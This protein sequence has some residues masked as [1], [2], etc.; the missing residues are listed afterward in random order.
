MT[1]FKSRNTVKRITLTPNVFSKQNRQYVDILKSVTSWN[2]RK[3][4]NIVLEGDYGTGKSSII[5]QLLSCRLW[6]ILH[7]PKC[8]SFLSFTLHS[9][10]SIAADTTDTTKTIQSEIIRQLCYGESP[11]TLK[12]TTYRCSG[13]TYWLSSA[14]AAV[15]ALI[16]FAIQNGN[17]SPMYFLLK[18]LLGTGSAQ[19]LSDNL[20][21]IVMSLRDEI[22][23]AISW[24]ITTCAINTII[25]ALAS[26]N[27]TRLSASNISVEFGDNQMDFQKMSDFLALY[28]RRTRHRVIV[29]E[30]LDRFHD[31]RIFEELRRLNTL[32]N[33]S[34][35]SWVHPKIKFIYTAS[36]D[37]RDESSQACYLNRDNYLGQGDEPSQTYSLNQRAKLFDIII[38]VVPF[39]STFNLEDNFVKSG[40]AMLENTFKQYSAQKVLH[41]SPN[42]ES[43]QAQSQKVLDECRKTLQ[44]FANILSRNGA[45]MR[46]CRLVLAYFESFVQ[47]YH[48][49]YRGDPSSYT[50]CLALS[51]IRAYYP[52][53][54][55]KLAFGQSVLNSIET[56]C[57]DSRSFSKIHDK[58]TLAS[59]DIFDNYPDITKDNQEIIAKFPVIHEILQNHLI[60]GDYCRFI[61]KSANDNPI[62][63]RAYNFLNNTIRANKMK[64]AFPLKEAEIEL[65]LKLADKV[66]FESVGMF[67]CD[68]FDYVASHDFAEKNDIIIAIRRLVPKQEE[69]F[70]DFYR[71]YY[72]CYR[73]KYAS[74]SMKAV[75]KEN[76]PI[77]Q[78]TRI[79]AG[80][81]QL[82]M[83]NILEVACSQY[84]NETLYK[85]LKSALQ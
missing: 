20:P 31:R 48:L 65:I 85:S 28:F 27:I 76:P 3:N 41:R 55:N 13:R 59:S 32:L 1:I 53:E 50:N 47:T 43:R 26:S 77:L 2:D 10:E 38:P 56:A 80:D 35:D 40:I 12:G 61:A 21:G 30:D 44:K 42:D 83:L 64:A 7:R 49:N 60:T 9:D 67:N 14:V 82:A 54:F 8:I 46:A 29:F 16:L 36:G 63:N 34:R 81:N 19:W 57:A 74:S 62:K 45:D 4:N 52:A 33:S 75:L 66:D 24:L 6:N 25:K 79:L 22:L 51:L 68:L 58:E 37:L 11:N 84:K 17:H 70:S 73:E 71:A 78:M 23:F 39:L 15:A 69:T 18:T 72:E 5:E